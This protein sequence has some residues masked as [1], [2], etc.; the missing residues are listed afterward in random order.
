MNP[1]TAAARSVHAASRVTLPLRPPSASSLS[2]CASIASAGR[3]RRIFVCGPIAASTPP[4]ASQQQPALPHP[5]PPIARLHARTP[6]R[7]HAQLA[8]LSR[9]ALSRRAPATAP[10][11]P[12]QLPRPPLLLA[13]LC[14]CSSLIDPTDPAAGYSH[15]AWLAAR[16]LARAPAWKLLERDPA[17]AEQRQPAR[18]S[19]MRCSLTDQACADAPSP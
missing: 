15:A 2:P 19:P 5:N 1:A 10:P 7:L 13:K 17:R 9:L 11:F 8:L 3:Q 18:A 16:P 14:R 6:A 12:L 4:P